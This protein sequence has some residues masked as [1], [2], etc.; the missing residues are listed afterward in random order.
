MIINQN[1]K[2]II[3]AFLVLMVFI[4]NS[5]QEKSD[6]IF[7]KGVS[8]A[9]NDL[10][11]QQITELEY[12]LF[13][14]IPSSPSEEISGSA[15][16]SFK[17]NDDS[18]P[19]ILDFSD[20]LQKI[21]QVILNGTV[22]EPRLQKGHIIIPKR[23]LNEGQQF[24]EINFIAGDQSLNRNDEFLYTLF[25][26]DRASSA[27]PCFDQPSL[28]AKFTLSLEVPDDWTAVANGKLSN[29]EE[30]EGKTTYHF[31]KTKPISTY[32]FAFTAGKYTT[33]T[34]EKDGRSI[35]LY[36][37]EPDQQKV[38]L[39]L[40]EI[41]RL[42]LDALEW[43]EEYTLIDYPF[44]KYDLVAIPSFQYSGME[45]P[46]A[47]L[48]RAEKLFL[49]ETA[50]KEQVLNRASLIAHETAHMWFGDLV[51]M[52]WFDDVWMKE[53]FANFMAAKVVNPAFPDVDHKLAFLI[54]H[55]PKAY[56]IDRT[57]GA[58]PIK[59]QL[60]N[61][62]MA[63]TLY[64]AIIYHK[65][66]IV[67]LHLEN[68]TGEEMLKDGLREYLRTYSYANADWTDLI[69]ILDQLTET[70][71]ENWSNVWVNKPGMP[72]YETSFSA[73]ELVVSQLINNGI[74]WT[75]LLNIFT[76][77]DEESRYTSVFDVGVPIKLSLEKE[78]RLVLP[79]G[80]I[81]EYGY[82]KMT[83]RDF[84]FLLFEKNLFTLDVRSR[85]AAYIS[86]W[87][88]MLKGNIKSE[89]LSESFKM[90][91]VNEDNEQ[92]IN[93]LLGYYS[94][95]FWRYTDES[96]RELLA[97]VFE[98][99]LWDK[100]LDTENPSLKAAYYKTYLNTALSSEAISKLYSIWNGELKIEGLELSA[101][102]FTTLSFELAVRADFFDTGNG[103]D[104]LL[105]IQLD[106][107]KNPDKQKRMAFIMP[108]LSLDE[109]IRDN[110][111]ESLSDPSNREH[112]PWVL[113]ALKY[114]HHPLRASSAR[115]YI[116]PS[117][118]MLEEIQV[119][120]DIFFP[121]GWLDATLGGHRNHTSADDVAI[122][123]KNKQDLDPKLRQKVLQ[124]AD[125]LF[126]AV[127]L[128]KK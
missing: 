125:P 74:S 56:S 108:A 116:L 79:N 91:L 99:I 121:K 8:I 22:I 109:S 32:L 36:H 67:M 93:L 18:K 9:L 65:A 20:S 5:C 80:N 30:Q 104:S 25:V 53:V 6:P 13:F 52:A 73:N 120:G 118:D 14:A 64:G 89:N 29:K 21:K 51:T 62:N 95:L 42:Q 58:N 111:F 87:E 16:T 50:T 84:N 94:E 83:Q 23:L 60:D 28:K 82:F 59:Q 1:S 126:R 76:I 70:N 102:D 34:R 128:S 68:I 103:I 61:M 124:S 47:V 90:F 3:N 69:K 97:N 75:Q 40:D 100:I 12:E 112:E 77:T 43:M 66:P 27:F 11:N 85:T 110:F 46:G 39:N 119:T 123:L 2:K 4:L 72:G 55:Y 31:E 107:L 106:R 37:R 88:N 7:D 96:S 63:G 101:G 117:L 98:P 15:K 115:K 44:G 33:V 71:L 48:Y 114:L 35:T 24:I 54:D 38:K 127:Q 81:V 41:F 26:P 57:D 78:P 10:R 113:T 17:L 122:F 45:H 19:V 86:L 105:T 92:V 49:D